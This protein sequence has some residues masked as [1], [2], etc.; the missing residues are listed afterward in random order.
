MSMV[1]QPK[2][3]T[4][5]SLIIYPL[6]SQYVPITQERLN[7][8]TQS[9]ML[10]DRYTMGWLHGCGQ[11]TVIFRQ[12]L[13]YL[14][15]GN[16]GPPQILKRGWL[17]Y[18]LWTE[19]LIGITLL[20]VIP[21]VTNYFFI[22]S[23]ISSENISG[24]YIYIC[25]CVCSD[26]WLWHSI[27]HSILAFYLAPILPSL[28]A[29]ILT[30]SLAFYLA[31]ALFLI[32]YLASILTFFLASIL[33]FYLALCDILF[34]QSIWQL[35]SILTFYSAILFGIHSGSLSGILLAFYLAFYSGTL[36]GIY[37]DILFGM[38]TAGPQLRAPDSSSAHWDLALAVEV[39]QRPMR[40]G[41]RCWEE[42]GGR[43]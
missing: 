26:I 11:G 19:T 4:R 13:R 23:G 7:P 24:I 9:Y 14:R 2:Q 33:A 40:S 31:V 27:W 17:E 36:S 39:R 37:S 16:L 21:T 42:E 12:H 32:F 28:L 6:C 25:V 5:S 41:V 29:S 22:A 35:A 8:S 20:W 30:F 15:Q 43:K 3:G 1:G 10:E 34:W 18:P 38:G